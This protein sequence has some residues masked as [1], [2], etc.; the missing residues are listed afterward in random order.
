[1]HCLYSVYKYNRLYTDF[2]ANEALFSKCGF[3]GDLSLPYQEPNIPQIP[4]AKFNDF[5]LHI[6]FYLT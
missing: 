5:P 1:M 4:I 3:I 6:P 2:S